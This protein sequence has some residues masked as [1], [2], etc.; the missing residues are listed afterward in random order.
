MIN[1]IEYL[2][3]KFNVSRKIKKVEQLFQERK[4]ALAL[5]DENP[6]KS[7]IIEMADLRMHRTIEK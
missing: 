4:N 6:T 2:S 3:L 5:D 7:Q 1:T